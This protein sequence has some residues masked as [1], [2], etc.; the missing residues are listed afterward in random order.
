MV[1]RQ[2]FCIKDDKSTFDDMLDVIHVGEKWFYM[3]KNTKKFYLFLR[4][5]FET[6]LKV[7]L[8][9][10]PPNSPDLNVL[11]VSF[12]KTIQSIQHQYEPKKHRRNG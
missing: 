11:D 6:G 3:T 10:Q 2:E 4:K 1:E 5:T 12:F 7:D 9:F 8:V